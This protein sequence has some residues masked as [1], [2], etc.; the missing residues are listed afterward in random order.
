VTVPFTQ[1]RDLRGLKEPSLCGHTLQLTTEIKY[2]GLILHK[3]STWKAWLKNV[4]NTA[5]RSF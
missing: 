4:M 5:Y 2:L 1:K 3:G